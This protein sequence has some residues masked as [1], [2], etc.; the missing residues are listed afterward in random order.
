MVRV[1]GEGNSEDDGEEGEREAKGGISG[2]GEKE[3]AKEEEKE[4]ECG[5]IRRDVTDIRR[6]IN[7]VHGI[8]AK[9]MY[10]ACEAQSWFGGRRAVYWRVDGG[11]NGGGDGRDRGIDS[12]GGGED[13]VGCAGGNRDRDRGGDV[14]MSEAG[15]EEGQVRLDVEGSL[16]ESRME[17]L[18]EKNEL[19]EGKEGEGEDSTKRL[20]TPV[21]TSLCRWGFYG[22]GFGDKTPMTWRV[23]DGK[24]T[25]IERE[26]RL[27][28][29]C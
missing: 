29:I 26:L 19:H 13:G 21:F 17:V 8:G 27:G 6:H 7:L 1:D 23:K 2:N 5:Y 24:E 20:E 22:K 3:K 11:G 16:E 9:G 15:D 14:V 18:N 4:K 10:E 12:V 28:K 25:E